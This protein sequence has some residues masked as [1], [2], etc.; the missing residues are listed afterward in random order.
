MR[1]PR[2]SAAVEPSQEPDT[3]ESPTVL[4]FTAR[5]AQIVRVLLA[6][7]A[8]LVI[9]HIAF[10]LNQFVA[11]FDFFASEA[12]FVLFDLS[13]EVTIPTWYSASL[14]LGCSLTVAAIAVVKRQRS[15]RYQYH[16]AGLSLIF[17]GLSI[18]DAADIHGMVSYRLSTAL[19][20]G[21]IMSYP[22]VIPAF[23]FVCVVGAVYVRFLLHLPPLV[24]WRFIVTGGLF[25]GAALGLEMLG[26]LWD[27]RYGEDSGVLHALITV[28]ETIEMVASIL[29]LG[30]ALA[31]LRSLGPRLEIRL[32]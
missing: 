31:Y 24:R 17:L 9:A 3:L 15:D 18:D 2:P 19:E 16:W 8:L 4:E 32:R 5:P 22:W 25:I 30:A 11:G 14:L 21:G 26:A 13:G 7:A 23:I 6:G 27:S 28:E 10:S 20:T 1:Q 12:L 29:F